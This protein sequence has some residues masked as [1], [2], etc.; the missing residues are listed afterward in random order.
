MKKKL[1]IVIPVLLILAGAGYTFTKP[2]VIVKTK[3]QGTI[4]LLPESFLLNLTD[5][6][7]AKFSVALL[8]P[9]GQSDGA[10]A[11]AAAGS[12]SN[13]DGTTL[14]TLPEEALIRDI[15]TNVVTDQTANTMISPSGRAHIKQLILKSILQETDVKVTA[16]LFP[17]LAVQ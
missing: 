11:A 12:D 3:V 1:M 13:S 4:Y 7:Y 2:K 16:V 5:N 14:G 8:L 17:D 10:S 6:R 15:I 9:P